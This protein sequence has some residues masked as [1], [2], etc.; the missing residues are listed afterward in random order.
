M[1]NLNATQSA[2]ILIGK[3][4]AGDLTEPEAVEL[5]RLFQADANLS[6]YFYRNV[7]ADFFL[8]ERYDSTPG[9]PP[10]TKRDEELSWDELVRLQNAEKPIAQMT[11]EEVAAY[12]A[13][14][15][16]PAAKLPSD[17]KK[18][19]EDFD[20]FAVLREEEERDRKAAVVKKK[21]RKPYKLT[22][23]DVFFALCLLLGIAIGVALV[24]EEFCP[25]S[26]H[27]DETFGFTGD[28]AIV[29]LADVK[30]RDD[31]PHYKRGQQLQNSRLVL[32]SGLVKLQFQS[33]AQMI[34]QGPAE[35][36]VQNHNA[37]Y[38][39]SGKLSA[40][41]PPEAVGFEVNTPSSK[42]VDRGTEFFVEIDK[43]QSDLEVVRGQVDC[44]SGNELP[45]SLT[46]GQ[47]VAIESTGTTR[48]VAT[49]HRFLP[50]AAFESKVKEY[51]RELKTQKKG[52][53]KKVHLDP[54][55]LAHFDLTE[56]I[57]GV[58]DNSSA[59]GSAKIP[60]ATLK[61]MSRTEGQLFDSSAVAFDSNESRVEVLFPETYESLTIKTSVRLDRLRRDG[62]V[63]FASEHYAELPGTILVQVLQSGQLQ[64]QVRHSA[65]QT[66]YCVSPPVLNRKFV[67]TWSEIEIV[68]D[69][70]KKLLSLRMDGRSLSTIRWDNP[71]PVVL[72]RA[73]I[74][75]V[76]GTDV[77]LRLRNRYWYGAIDDIQIYN[78]ALEK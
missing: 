47:A 21:K 8:K 60:Q 26:H 77:G 73:S 33:N 49:A 23:S 54:T 75:N 29:E 78:R 19:E 5:E 55:L 37:V 69:G 11:P 57:T 3:Y 44:L 64:L 6:R 17:A 61:G 14:M 10:Q 46:A 12:R 34:V 59:T 16:V 4:L 76:P 72:G 30:F 56:G 42:I 74:G 68:I 36:L 53:L 62:S 32:E 7:L 66:Q 38:C 25:S 50:K 35:L 67:G 2:H 70:Q 63:L 13:R 9:N 18:Q 20:P 39:S 45:V 52:E 1:P 43:E 51:T 27:E 58:V 15:A 28:A 31:A 41:V 22:A 24:R 40:T 48:K 71:M 65:N